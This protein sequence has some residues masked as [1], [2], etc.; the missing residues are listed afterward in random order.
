M[1]GIVFGTYST[2][3]IASPLVLWLRNREAGQGQIDTAANASD[4]NVA[5]KG[6]A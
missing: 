5:V 1:L 4:E 3:F 2:M 6:S